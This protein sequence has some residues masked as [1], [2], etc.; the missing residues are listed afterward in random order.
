M[1]ARTQNL[2]KNVR[3]SC[4]AHTS[5]SHRC[6]Q[7]SRPAALAHLYWQDK[8]QTS[9]V[10]TPWLFGV[11]LWWIYIPCIWP[12]SSK[13]L[14]VASRQSEHHLHYASICWNYAFCITTFQK[15][16]QIKALIRLLCWKHVLDGKLG[17]CQKIHEITAGHLS[18]GLD[19]SPQSFLMFVINAK[20]QIGQY[21]HNPQMWKYSVSL[22]GLKVA[23]VH[24][25]AIDV[26]ILKNKCHFLQNEAIS[27]LFVIFF[28]VKTR[29]FM[30]YSVKIARRAMVH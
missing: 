7:W 5:L 22:S 3:P 24:S 18:F 21:H 6:T 17:Q 30:A 27:S 8:Q 11:S 15:Y 29:S 23:V 12:S 14:P 20:F 25:L 9:W 2:S 28:L 1:T 10:I 19:Q 26:R 16:C 4:W 13:K